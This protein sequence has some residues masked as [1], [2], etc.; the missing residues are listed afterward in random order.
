MKTNLL[1][2]EYEYDCICMNYIWIYNINIMYSSL[3]NFHD[4]DASPARNH[5]P[6]CRRSI[7]TAA[8]AC[9]A[10]RA[11]KIEKTTVGMK[12]TWSQPECWAI[13]W[14]SGLQ[15]SQ[16]HSRCIKARWTFCIAEVPANEV[17]AARNVGVAAHV[18]MVFANG[19]INK[20]LTEKHTV[21][22]I[23]PH[24]HIRIIHVYIYMIHSIRIYH[25]TV[26]LGMLHLPRNSDKI[27]TRWSLISDLA[28]SASETQMWFSLISDRSKLLDVHGLR[29][30]R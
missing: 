3:S 30:P 15:W 5:A 16:L 9:R 25:S 10:S 4:L 22:S 26:Y 23:I 28:N 24:I 20:S 21:I 12:S 19:G 7:T 27:V 17:L 11:T 14:I 18:L 1:P 6:C 29:K 8:S 13:F 2:I